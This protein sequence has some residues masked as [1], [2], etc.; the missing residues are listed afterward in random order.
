MQFLLSLNSKDQFDECAH[1]YWNRRQ[2]AFPKSIFFYF[3]WNHLRHP[4]RYTRHV[5]L[6]RIV[7]CQIET[8][9]VT[10]TSEPRP[11]AAPSK[12]YSGRSVSS[13][14]PISSRSE[15]QDPG[16]EAEKYLNKRSYEVGLII[17][18][19]IH[20]LQC[21]SSSI[22]LRLIFKMFWSNLF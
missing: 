13:S 11:A 2:L 3:F 21:F 6:R 19:Y 14:R 1:E 15:R 20:H 9:T 16:D 18:R 8:T 10:S 17:T 22:F 5:Y 7:C 4:S 12:P